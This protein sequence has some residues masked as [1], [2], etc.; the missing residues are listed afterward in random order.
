MRSRFIDRGAIFAGWVGIGVALVV[1]IAFEL[2][3]AVQALV[4]ILAPLM[5]LLIGA[6][7][8]TR[9]ERHR[10][11]SRVLANAAYAGLVTAVGLAL[12]Y[13]GLRLLFVYGDS[14]YRSESQ[15]GQLP[16][17]PGPDCTYQRLLGANGAPTLEA[18][19][20]TDAAGFEGLLIRELLI[21]S[22]VLV[23]LTL[24]GA[25]AGG[26]I[27][28]LGRPPGQPTGSPGTRNVSNAAPGPEGPALQG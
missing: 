12:L 18:A 20:V 7:A 13:G 26:V 24:G 8:N 5:G 1:V 27:K 11:W 17:R 14:G 3:I 22:G 28:G 6:Y 16:C 23:T 4:F 10:P 19:G 2:I 9:S 21:G 25:V 15:G